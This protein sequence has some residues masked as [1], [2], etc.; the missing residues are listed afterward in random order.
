V[1]ES[2]IKMPIFVSKVSHIRGAEKRQRKSIQEQIQVL[3]KTANEQELRSMKSW[4]KYL[5]DL[6]LIE[7]NLVR[8]RDTMENRVYLE[9]IEKKRQEL[10]LIGWSKF[11]NRPLSMLEARAAM[12]RDHMNDLNRV[13]TKRE[14]L[15]LRHW[16][17][18]TDMDLL[19]K[20]LAILKLCIDYRL[21]SRGFFEKLF[22][23]HF[24]VKFW[25]KKIFKLPKLTS[26]KCQDEEF[27]FYSAITTDRNP[28][29]QQ[30]EL[31][32]PCDTD[33]PSLSSVRPSLS[34]GVS[35]DGESIYF[36]PKDQL[37]T[38]HAPIAGGIHK[39][40]HITT[41][42]DFEHVYNEDSEDGCWNAIDRIYSRKNF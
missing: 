5:H 22:D 31:L 20:N 33:V 38:H 9:N 2:S 15:I 6:D 41:K 23:F 37:C 28:I 40:N 11:S 16:S 4:V 26:E 17:L 21:E 39:S 42:V 18:E 30:S 14:K 1:V 7:K 19:E 29:C 3:S 13:A 35:D 27:H 12:L 32:V 8:L 10:E 24:K 34:C 25:P 36:M